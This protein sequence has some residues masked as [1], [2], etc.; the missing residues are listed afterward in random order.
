MHVNVNIR[1]L[2]YVQEFAKLVN[3]LLLKQERYLTINACII[4]LIQPCL[5]FQK[6]FILLD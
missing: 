1:V 5:R 3:C 6:T 4:T 2:D